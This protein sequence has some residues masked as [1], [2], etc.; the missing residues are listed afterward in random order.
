MRGSR[1]HPLSRLN[2]S[3]LHMQLV[4][5]KVKLADEVRSRAIHQQAR[6]RALTML[7]ALQFHTNVLLTGFEILE[8]PSLF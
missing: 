3:D 6:L 5:I 4:L 8:L 7:A 2:L 1:Q